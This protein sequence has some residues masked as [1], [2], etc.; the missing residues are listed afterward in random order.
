MADV[1]ALLQEDFFESCCEATDGDVVDGHSFLLGELL[2]FL[3]FNFLEGV[4]AIHFAGELFIFPPYRED[5]Q[6]W[7]RQN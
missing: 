3:E 1:F 5:V 7:P 4:C 6:I 2:Q